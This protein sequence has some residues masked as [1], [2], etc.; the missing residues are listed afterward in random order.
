MAGSD[1]PPTP[2]TRTPTA[3]SVPRGGAR[4]GV[5]KRHRGGADAQLRSALARIS[6]GSLRRLA[7][8]GGEGV[9]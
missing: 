9:C 7:R 6:D 5:R 8:R 2:G 4:L 1:V 3:G